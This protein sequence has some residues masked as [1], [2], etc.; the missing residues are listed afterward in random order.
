M[1]DENQRDSEE[2][3]SDDSESTSSG[4]RN[5]SSFTFFNSLISGGLLA[6]FMSV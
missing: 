3:E 1:S 2:D 4:E 6:F 5:G